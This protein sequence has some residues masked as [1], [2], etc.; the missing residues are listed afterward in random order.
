MNKKREVAVRWGAQIVELPED[1][2]RKWGD[3]TPD[4]FKLIARDFLDLV[5][6]KYVKY[7][8]H[9]AGQPALVCTLVQVLKAC[10]IETV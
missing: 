5:Q 2:K 3:V 6:D 9:L 7:I 4:N 8:V 1:L 10:N